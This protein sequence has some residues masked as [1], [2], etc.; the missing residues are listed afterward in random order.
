MIVRE[1]G[2]KTYTPV[3]LKKKNQMITK[4]S[5]VKTVGMALLVS[6]MIAEE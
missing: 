3:L 5:V 1:S 6:N 4:P 2:K